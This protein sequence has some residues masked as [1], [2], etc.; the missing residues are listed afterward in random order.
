MSRTPPKSLFELYEADAYP[1]YQFQWQEVVTMPQ[2]TENDILYAGKLREERGKELYAPL[3][4]VLTS[5][6]LYRMIMPP[7]SPHGKLSLGLLSSVKNIAYLYL[8][9]PRLTRFK[10][11]E[12]YGLRLTSCQNVHN[13]VCGSK[14]ELNVWY[15]RLKQVSVLGRIA[16]KYTVGKVLGRGSYATVHAA[17]RLEDQKEVAVKTISK[18]RISNNTNVMV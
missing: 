3:Y 1:L 8:M 2:L 13:F 5:N 11:G 15:D 10:R 17:V 6:K 9:N 16:S 12:I 7:S 14:D 18:E 4:Y